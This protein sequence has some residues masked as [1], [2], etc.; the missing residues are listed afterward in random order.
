MALPSTEH[1]TTLLFVDEQPVRLRLGGGWWKITDTPTRIR[2]T[3]WAI[4]LDNPHPLY[5]WRFQ[6]TNEQNVSWTVDVY[7][8]EDGWYVQR[9]YQ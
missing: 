6:I 7:K 3:V 5:G 1:E 8:G 4:P 9:R 2:E